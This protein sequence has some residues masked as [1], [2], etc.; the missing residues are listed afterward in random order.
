MLE[1]DRLRSGIATLHIVDILNWKAITS[2]L[3]V[4]P[5]SQTVHEQM[6]MFNSEN[7]VAKPSF[8]VS[9]ALQCAGE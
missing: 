3:A 6:M 9:S 7:G 4:N 2:G 1:S 5:F 8:T